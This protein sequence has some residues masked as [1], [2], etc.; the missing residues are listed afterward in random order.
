MQ[1]FGYEEE[2]LRVWIRYAD[3]QDMQLANGF[4]GTRCA[5]IVATHWLASAAPGV[6]TPGKRWYDCRWECPP[7]LS[8]RHT[9]G[10][11]QEAERSKVRQGQWHCVTSIR[12]KGEILAFSCR[13]CCVWS[14]LDRPTAAGPQHLSAHTAL[15]SRTNN[16]R[17]C[18]CPLFSMRE[19][20][21]ERKFCDSVRPF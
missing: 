13:G 21:P 20:V 19:Y 6:Q 1:R 4:Q 3:M 9:L 14:P 11:S 15:S 8:C 2:V 16:G 5:V 17:G 12:F 10:R 18:D 7:W